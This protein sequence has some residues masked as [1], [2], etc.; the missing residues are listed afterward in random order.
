MP[1]VGN[2]AGI[3]TEGQVKGILGT[4]DTKRTLLLGEDSFPIL[5]TLDCAGKKAEEEAWAWP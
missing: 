3:Q 1:A 2:S 4:W 5:T